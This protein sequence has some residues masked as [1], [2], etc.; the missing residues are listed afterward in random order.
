MVVSIKSEEGDLLTIHVTGH[1]PFLTL[2]G[3]L[4]GEGFTA[5][6]HPEMLTDE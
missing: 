5:V 2:D 1:P 6:G 4:N 3:V